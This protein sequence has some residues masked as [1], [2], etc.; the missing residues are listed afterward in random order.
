MTVR[1]VIAVGVLGFFIVYLSLAVAAGVSRIRRL[2]S[3]R[4]AKRRM[5]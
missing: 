1:R 5:A 2:L 4:V 3:A